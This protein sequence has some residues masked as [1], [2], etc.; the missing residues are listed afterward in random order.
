MD[1]IMDY[2]NG[3]EEIHYY[4]DD[5]TVDDNRRLL[6]RIILRIS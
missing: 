1:Y 3:Y 4:E 5:N 6:S 2:N